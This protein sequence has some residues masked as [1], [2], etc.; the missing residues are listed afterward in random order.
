MTPRRLLRQSLF[1]H[2]R[3]NAAVFLGVAV[4]TAVLTGA[5]LVGDSMR[6]SLRAQ[7]IEQLGWVD[8][9]L[10]SGRF[11]RE[12][13]AS[14]LPA[15]RVVPVI[16]LRGAATRSNQRGETVQRAGRVNIL[17]VND[18][19]WTNPQPPDSAWQSSEAEVV[20]NQALA[21]ELSA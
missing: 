13:L 21:D 10:V 19:F 8:R 9:A 3:G 11:I 20:L 5:L 2:W 12:E 7:V 17:G 6:G 18:R 4:A 1:Y 16:L 14:G 15:E